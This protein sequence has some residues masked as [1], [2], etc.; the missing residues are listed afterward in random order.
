MGLE[1]GVEIK[2]QPVSRVFI[3]SCTNSRI[4]DLRLA[5]RIL[6][7]RRVA[8][9]TTLQVVPGSQAVKK[10]AEAEGLDRIFLDAGG[11]W[12]DPS[13]S[14]CVCMNGEKAAPGQYVASTSNRNFPGRQGAGVRTFLMSPAMAAATAVSGRVQD[15]RLFA[16]GQTRGRTA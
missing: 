1:P 14:L 5:A 9:G 11:S 16:D 7:G 2:G 8:A 15:P 3:G 6:D 13:C 12:N 4:E 10:Q